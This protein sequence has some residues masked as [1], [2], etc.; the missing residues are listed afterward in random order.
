M[1]RVVLKTKASIPK[2][3]QNLPNCLPCH[4]ACVVGITLMCFI[5][6]TV[7]RFHEVF[8][9]SKVYWQKVRNVPAI[10]ET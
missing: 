2:V 9:M 10:Q 3:H 8:Q 5:L 4:K 7:I 1:K 6:G